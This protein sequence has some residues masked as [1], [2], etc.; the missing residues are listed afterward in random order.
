MNAQAETEIPELSLY[1]DYD[2]E[3]VK[4]IFEPDAPFTPGA[5]K[6][7]LTGIVELPDDPGSYVFFVSFGRSQGEHDFDEGINKEGL[8]RWQSQ[9][10]QD[11][12]DRRIQN[13]ISH[14]PDINAIHLFLR[15]AIRRDGA[16][17]PFTYLGELEYAGHD[18]VREKPVYFSWRL[19]CWP[20]PEEVR[21]RIQLEIEGGEALSWEAAEPPQ[22][23]LLEP[24]G[25]VQTIL[26]APRSRSEGSPARRRSFNP[27]LDINFARKSARAK[28]IG[29]LGERLVVEF[30]MKRL[31]E[32]GR[33]DL[34]KRV[35]HVAKEKGDGAG[36]DV[37]SFFEDGREMFIEV[38]STT[39][40]PR[41]DFL[42]SSNELAFASKHVEQYR[43]YRLYHLKENSKAAEF[44]ALEGD[45]Q[46]QF[47]LIPT[48]YRITGF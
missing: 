5:G 36:Y 25:L 20:I 12:S 24:G 13:F 21:E 7:G 47:E 10:K 16:P 48:E 38:K 43:L 40:G 34:A 39:S 45:I 9:P 35:V 3:A 28:K 29:D 41:T 44:F 14:N 30:E 31:K 1:S 32:A 18:P 22:E 6:W 17:A 46:T 15:T 8:L 23:E 11:L 2:R 42:I 19:K 4:N 26:P 33:E 37:L 27:R